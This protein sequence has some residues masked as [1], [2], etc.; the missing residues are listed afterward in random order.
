MTEPTPGPPDP[1]EYKVYRSRKRPLARGGDLD[2]LQPAAR[3][4]SRGDEPPARAA[5]RSARSRRGACSSG[6]RSRSPAGS[7]LSLVLFLVSAQPPRR[8]SRPTAEQ[9]LSSGGNLLTGSTILVLGSDA[10]TGESIDE[11]ARGPAR[12]DTIMLVHAALGSVRKLSIPRDVEVDDP[13]PR[14]R[15]DQRGLRARRRRADDRDGRGVP[16]QRARD[17]PPRRGRLRGLPGVHR[18]A[19]RHH[20]RVN[21]SRICSPP[22]RQL[23]EGPPLQEGRE[24]AGR[25]AGARLR[26]RAQEPVRPGRGRPRPRR[27]P[28]G[29]AARDRRQVKS[30]STFFRLPLGELDRRP[31]RSRPTWAAS[32]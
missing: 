30:P 3:R 27:P 11:S 17:Q 10:R 1:P 24:R 20:R 25:P 29:G 4:R 5:R 7:L 26:A 8:A 2:A 6:W 18:L 19:R 12:S 13:R 31:R 23:L 15:Q 28:A 16:R 32:S 9:A 21:K 22:V 14:D